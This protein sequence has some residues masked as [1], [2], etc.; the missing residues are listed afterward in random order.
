[1]PFFSD[2]TSL[3]YLLDTDWNN[4]RFPSRSNS[5]LLLT[6]VYGHAHQYKAKQDKVNSLVTSLYFILFYFI[7]QQQEETK[8]TE[9][10][11]QQQQQPTESSDARTCSQEQRQK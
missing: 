10:K 7:F 8:K 11:Q 2:Y 4:G 1:M 5:L 3:D 9:R 6:V